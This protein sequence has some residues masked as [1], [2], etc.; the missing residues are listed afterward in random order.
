VYVLDVD[1]DGWEPT[2]G[3]PGT[4][5]LALVERDDYHAGVFRITGEAGARFQWAPEHRETIFLL[6]GSVRIRFPDGD[7]LELEPG[8]MASLPGDVTTDWDVTT[9]FKDLYVIA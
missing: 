6:E 8:D 4:E 7:V 2:P 1:G 9:P 5:F 3:Y